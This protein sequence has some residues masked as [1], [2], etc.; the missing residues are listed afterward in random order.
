[1]SFNFYAGKMSRNS[2]NIFGVAVKQLNLN[3]KFRTNFFKL[4][5]KLDAWKERERI[6][7]HD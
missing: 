4:Y 5:E 7:L 6:N 1:M 2:K 3:P